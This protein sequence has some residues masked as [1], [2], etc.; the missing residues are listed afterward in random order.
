M[1]DVLNIQTKSVYISLFKGDIQV[2]N[3]KSSLHNFFLLYIQISSVKVLEDSL[4]R[5]KKAEK[6]STSG[7]SFEDVKNQ[8]S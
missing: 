2:L 3:Q 8:D 1:E 5:D 6:N 4:R 7:T